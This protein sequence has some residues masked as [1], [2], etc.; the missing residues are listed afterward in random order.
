[1]KGSVI[2]DNV[3][4]KF[5]IGCC[6]QNKSA[7]GR[8]VSLFSGRESKKDFHALE[9]ISF[10]VA[11]GKNLGII[12]RNGSGKSTLLRLIA[13]V[14][15]PDKGSIKTEGNVVCLMGFGYG[16][17]QKLTM[18]E[19]IYLMGSIMGLS[20]KDIKKRFNEIVEFSG[21][22]NF[23]DTKVYQ[24]S[25]G[26]ITRLNFSVTIHCVKH[27]NP[28]ILLLDEVFGA[29]GDIDFET[30]ALKKMEELVTGG[31]TVILSTHDLNVVEKYCDMAMWLDKGKIIK[32][33][34]PSDI[35]REYKKF[36]I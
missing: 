2:A 13:G 4:K 8:I 26:M 21:L 32:T 18:R 14:Y 23:L 10:S 29:G 15:R 34:N 6:D 30:K 11:P 7:L 27:S 16:L 5:K 25:S 12:G 22:P 1:M 31:T 36:N 35:V 33:G 20:P 9:D 28:D 24:F 3:S 19:N 17:N